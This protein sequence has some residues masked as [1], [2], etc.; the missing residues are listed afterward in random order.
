MNRFNK[1][2]LKDK[3]SRKPVDVAEP[4]EDP[5]DVR[6]GEKW[7]QLIANGTIVDLNNPWQFGII[8]HLNIYDD[9]SLTRMIKDFFVVARSFQ[10]LMGLEEAPA[11]EMTVTELSARVIEQFAQICFLWEK[12]LKLLV[13]ETQPRGRFGNQE[14]DDLRTRVHRIRTEL[15]E[16]CPAARLVAIQ[17]VPGRELEIQ[18]QMERD[19]QAMREIREMVEQLFRPDDEC[20]R[21]M[22][23]IN[24]AYSTNGTQGSSASHNQRSE[25]S[26]NLHE[27]FQFMV[28]HGIRPTQENVDLVRRRAREARE[29]RLRVQAL[30]MSFISAYK[31]QLASMD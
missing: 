6:I 5:I 11:P 3:N 28:P 27:P 16:R 7:D 26:N 1:L 21:M 31:R 19:N 25:D 13:V 12:Y 24:A 20:H 15:F 2:R 17:E 22:N 4:P 18:R 9:G 30:G 23:V 14:R 29:A 10:N 8:T